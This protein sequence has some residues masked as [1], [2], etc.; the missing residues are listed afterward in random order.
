V[1]VASVDRSLSD[2]KLFQPRRPAL[3]KYLFMGKIGTLEDVRR[4]VWD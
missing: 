2:P 4:L 1:L 3:I